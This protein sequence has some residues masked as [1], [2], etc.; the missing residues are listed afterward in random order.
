MNPRAKE[1]RFQIMNFWNFCFDYEHI[2]R[3]Q[4]YVWDSERTKLWHR[5]YMGNQGQGECES[6]LMIEHTISQIHRL[7]T[8]SQVHSYFPEDSLE[9]LLPQW[10]LGPQPRICLMNLA[11]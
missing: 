2:D 8:L 1:A 11:C 9:L 5:N 7:E 4:N 10:S 3:K 6:L